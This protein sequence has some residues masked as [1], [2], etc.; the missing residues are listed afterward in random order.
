MSDRPGR[1]WWAWLE[2][3]RRDV[4]HAWAGLAHAPEF[5]AS[6]VLTLALG[7]GVSTAV[8]SVV[9]TVLLEPLPYKDADQLVR[10]VERAAPRTADGPL[11]RRT[12]MAWFEFAEW[13]QRSTT[14][15][16]MVYTVSPPI[17]LMPTPSGSARLTGALVSSNTFAFLG[18]TARLGRT[19][20]ASD[21]AVG[22][23][24]VVIS[25][26]AWQRYFQ[27]DPGIIGRTMTL[28]TLGPEAGFLDGTPLT[29]VG[30]MPD[31]FDFPFPNSDYWAPI[32]KGSTAR[33]ARLAGNVI[34]R[35]RDGVSV[36]AANDEANA[37]GDGLR[38]KPTSGFLARPLPP[39]VRRFDVEGVKEQI[40]SS[41]RP[42]L[43]VLAIAMGAVL[44]MVCANVASLLL[45]RGTARQREVA[46]RLALG[47]S[48]GRVIRQLLTESAVLAALGGSVGVLVSFGGVQFL[49]EFGSPYAPGPFRISFGAAM[50]P[51]LHEIR[52]DERL[53][54][55]TILLIGLTAMLV[56]VLPAL[57]MSQ[58][59]PGHAL[60]QKSPTARRSDLLVRDGLVV[61]QLSVATIL[62]IGAG[63]LINSFAKLSRLDPGWNG[64]GVLTF[65]LVMPHDYPTVRKA[66]LIENLLSE[67]RRMPDVRNA[68]F[69]YAGPLL[70]LIDTFGVFVPAGRTVE[71]MRER[72]DLPHI[73]AVSHDYFQTMG[74]RLLSGRWFEPRDDGSAPAV[75]IVNRAVMQRFFNNQNPVGQ[76]V[77]VD[78]RMDLPPQ[79]IIGVVEDMR[80]GR[81]DQEPSP[82]IFV[83]YRQMLALTQARTLPTSVQ[84]RLA[85]GFLSFVVQ[86]DRDPAAL[87]PTVRSLVGRLD[88]AAGI[89]AILPMQEL[90]SAS[91][92]RQ[93]FYAMLL[94]FFAV[95]AALLG[96]VGIYGVLAYA[97]GQRT[98]EF[99]VR[100]ALG[101]QQREV[102]GLVLRRGVLLASIGMLIGIAGAVALTR[103]LRGML[104][105]LAPLDP[106]T[107]LV[108][109]ILFAAVALIAAYLPARRATSV[110]PMVALRSE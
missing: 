91:L 2:D 12:N 15:S 92:T 28:E 67:L 32:G 74:V 40:V 7:I 42:A 87:A 80:Q 51:R 110:D 43:R 4:P 18:A 29:I 49:R 22:A 86:T 65:Y 52:A 41:S 25:S 69:T 98:Q 44:L 89:D 108:V 96:T 48:R 64:S 31:S 9:N 99:A 35:L 50:L 75:I 33:T 68:G 6:A 3:I 56:G 70:G 14:L 53:L 13:R 109:T 20:D 19:L 21:D 79:Q 16:D 84:E 26:T 38:P 100:M 57:R 61:G 76:M 85:F 104:F 62:L 11:L 102:L 78:G 72:T 71:D 36:Q 34:A 24:T 5:T 63:L 30:V 27:G 77:H 94:G 59:G 55:L 103:Y 105:G 90:V 8:F 66:S 37:V 93:R 97:V 45:A 60:N 101:A 39:G 73:R 46:V 17:T 106:A 58:T 107:Y 83:D 82:Q 23:N 81:L 54:V 10:I 95:V 1:N 88:S 47:A